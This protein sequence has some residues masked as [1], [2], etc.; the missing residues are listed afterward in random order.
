[1]RRLVGL[2]LLLVLTA[3]ALY[4]WKA[5]AEPPI[6]IEGLDARRREPGRV[7]IDEITI[8]DKLPA[9]LEAA[10]DK[11]GD[12]AVRS[13]V[14]T[15]FALH[16][17][18]RPLDLQVEAEVR[19]VTL[20][21]EAP[22]DE[23]RATAERIARLVPEVKDVRNEIR[24]RSGP[25]SPSVMGRSLGEAVDDE[26]LALQVRLAIALNRRLAGLDL[27]VS[28][29]RGEARLKGDVR[30]AEEKALAASVARDVPGVSGVTDSLRIAG[31]DV[32]S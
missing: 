21:G 10:K 14:K 30:T 28:V 5:R 26:T 4:Y 29:F 17:S 12:A 2:V 16:R 8:P 7:V 15:A 27:E 23:T 6:R 18:L 9:P 31:D 32:K 1:M 20:R 19:V 11:L 22:S 24:V 25:S 13:S 3:A